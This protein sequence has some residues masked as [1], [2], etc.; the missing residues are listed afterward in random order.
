VSDD[1]ALVTRALE[2]DSDAVRA[3]DAAVRAAAASA[4]RRLAGDHALADEIA[5]RVSERLWIG[6]DGGDPALRSYTGEAPLAAWLKIIAYR[7]G[8]D[9]RRVRDAPGDDDLIERIVGA[10]ETHMAMLRA[11]Y[12]AAFKRCFKAALAALSMHDRDLV[13]RHYLDGLTLDALGRLHATHRATI[14]RQLARIRERLVDETRRALRAELSA[15]S[16]LEDV[17]QLI[18]SKLEASLSREP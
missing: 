18:G 15:S 9:L 12:L 3:V 1:L 17:L 4:A 2:R 5:Q 6:R 14:A 7:E 13:R 8:V 10:T 11:T 16:D